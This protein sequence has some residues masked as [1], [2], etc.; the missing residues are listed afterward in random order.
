MVKNPIFHA[1]LN[2]ALCRLGAGDRIAILS[3]HFPAP[4]GIPLIDLALCAG[5]PGFE[6]VLTLLTDQIEVDQMT[7]TEELIKA[8]D[9]LKNQLDSQ[10]DRMNIKVEALT[11]RQFKILTKSAR[12]AIRTGETEVQASLVLRVR[13]VV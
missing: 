8:D 3:A 1:E 9:R 10:A 12:F 7:R 11:Y 4:E 6:Q 13:E 5:I 2:A